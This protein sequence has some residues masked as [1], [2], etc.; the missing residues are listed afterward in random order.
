MARS[1]EPGRRLLHVF[2]TFGIGGYQGRFVSLANALGRKYTHNI[3]A[4]DGNIAA[5]EGLRRD[6]AFTIETIPVRKTAAIS[7][8]NLLNARRAL[9]RLHPD[10]LLTYNWGSIEW[11]LANRPQLCRHI[12]FEDG[13][14]PD[15][16]LARQNWRR[17]LVRRLLLSRG[18]QVVVPSAT[19]VALATEV[20]R[21][22]RAGVLHVPNGIDCERF[23]R[24]A[25]P[26]LLA[27]FGLTG[28][29][30]VIGTVAGLRGEKNVARLIRVFSALPRDLGARLVIVGDGPERATLGELA[31][32][33]EIGDRIVFTGPLAEP[34]RMLGRFA[35]FALS[36]DTEQ[37]PNVILE[38]MAAGLPIVAT[39][40]G[41]VKRIVAP[42]NAGSIV[43]LDDEAAFA[44]SSRRC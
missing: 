9:R 21:L 27:S 35:I 30:P 1:A 4:M 13:F 41:D 34:E 40:V 37:M 20:W 43:P 14:G 39:D 6:V 29:D 25:D 16:S 17:V 19:L 5:A 23:A 2:S 12:H 3:L 11:S 32:R 22:P 24:P 18:V 28:D 44:R 42:E 36:S 33:S 31:A 10:L 15:K 38:A 8:A 7:L 26:A